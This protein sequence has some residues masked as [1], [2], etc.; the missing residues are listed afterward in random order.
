MFKTLENAGP[1]GQQMINEL[2]GVVAEHI[3]DEATKNTRPDINGNP[4]VSVAK[5]DPIIKKLDKSGK[6]DLIFGKEAA[7]RYRTLNDVTKD[8]YTVPEGSVNTSNTASNLKSYVADIATT[9]ALS[10]V[11]APAVHLL[12]M[13]KEEVTKRRDLNRI[14]EFI[15]YGKEK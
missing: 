6:L 2:R 15:N 8:I 3:K 13:G 1:E 11:P 9:Y 14:N 5:L 7:A 4:V 10:G 12:K